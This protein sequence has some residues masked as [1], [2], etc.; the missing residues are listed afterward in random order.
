MPM[1]LTYGFMAF[2]EIEDYLKE[3]SVPE[4]Y[5]Y[6]VLDMM[7]CDGSVSLDVNRKDLIRAVKMV[8]SIEHDYPRWIGVDE[9]N[10][11]V[12]IGLWFTRGTLTLGKTYRIGS[13][14]LEEAK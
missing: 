3:Q 8:T 12:A 7:T 9:K 10:K 6:I 11:K 4:D 14:G 2:K 1:T 5:D 13:N